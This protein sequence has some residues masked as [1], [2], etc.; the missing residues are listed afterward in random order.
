MAA[1]LAAGSRR[2]A[3]A[4]VKVPALIIHGDADPLAPVAGGIATARAIPGAR[5]LVIKDMGHALPI[6][7]WPEIIEAI[8][9]HAT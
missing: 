4:S 7:M 8:A 6:P 9:A 3:L 2:D 1:I 5:L